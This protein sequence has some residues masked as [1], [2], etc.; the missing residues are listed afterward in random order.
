M[1]ALQ[2][3]PRKWKIKQQSPETQYTQYLLFLSSPQT[4]HTHASITRNNI[5][6]LKY[7]DGDADYSDGE[8][9]PEHV[10]A[11]HAALRA[12]TATDV[13]GPDLA[14]AAVRRQIYGGSGG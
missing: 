2:I 4:S 5:L 9:E 1:A 12:L 10:T 8:S 3:L 13:R 6:S 11:A 14:Y 7:N